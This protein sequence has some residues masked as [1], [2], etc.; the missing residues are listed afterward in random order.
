MVES[1]IIV[2]LD[3]RNEKFKQGAVHLVVDVFDEGFAREIVRDDLL[4]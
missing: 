2:E 1:P 4:Q 3:G